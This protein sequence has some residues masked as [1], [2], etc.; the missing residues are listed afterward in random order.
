LHS[1]VES[2][3]Q[4]DVLLALRRD[5]RS[6]DPCEVAR[7]L[8]CS[9]P[10]ARDHLERLASRGLLDVKLGASDVMYRYDPASADLRDAV[11]LTVQC[12]AESRTAVMRFVLAPSRR[13]ARDFAEAFRLR[14]V[15]RTQR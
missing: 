13:A 3:D 9:A 4:L 2:I 6:L 8:G 1:C 7:L 12:Y 14:D 10:A 5:D 15:R 11:E